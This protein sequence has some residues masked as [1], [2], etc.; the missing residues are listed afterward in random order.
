MDL[1]K[2]SLL[3]IIGSKEVK[4]TACHEAKDFD[5][6]LAHSSFVWKTQVLLIMVDAMSWS[7]A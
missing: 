2:E 5:S 6:I 1:A 3:P 7:F 4:G